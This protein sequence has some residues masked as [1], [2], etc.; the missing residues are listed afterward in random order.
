MLALVTGG[1]ARLGAAIAARLARDGYDLALHVRSAGGVPEPALAAEIAERGVRAEQFGADLADGGA[2]EALVGRVVDH[3]GRAPDLLVNSAAMF[4]EGGWATLERADLDRHLA[5][6]FVTPLMLT[7][8]AAVAGTRAVVNVI[9]QRIAN[10][11]ID[12]AAYT[13]S[14]LAL[15]AST[16]VLAR[17]FAPMRV[18]AIAPGLT[19]PGPEYAKGQIAALAATMPL[20]RLPDP[21]D[22]AD[23]VAY[24]AGAEAVT[25]QTLYVD[26]G[27]AME[28][29]RRDF[30]HLARD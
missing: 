9:D 14:K 29:F 16:R 19:I 12:Q 5:V 11:P 4:E 24:L 25:G 15:G 28:S 17:A 22:V 21:A 18:N 20:E 3:F 2:V 7:R 8:A 26:G 27:A 23:A 30:V 10:P 13:A 1:M 6:N